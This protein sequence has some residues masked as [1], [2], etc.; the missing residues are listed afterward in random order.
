MGEAA[1]AALALGKGGEGLTGLAK[2]LASDPGFQAAA[3]ALAQARKLVVFYGQEGL[4][5]PGTRR[6]AQACARLLQSTGHAGKPDSGLVAVWGAGNLQGA[7]DVGLRPPEAG[8]ASA[9]TGAQALY[10]VGADPVGDDSAMAESARAASTLVVQELFLSATARLADVVLPAQSFV[11]RQGS[12]T[13]GERR[14]QRFYPALPAWGDTRP[15]WLISAELGQRLGIPLEAGSVAAV[16]AELAASAP[17]YAGL[18]YARLAQVGPQWPRIGDSDL[19]YGG[20]GYSNHQGLGVKLT[21]TA[22]AG[23]LAEVPLD[24]AGRSPAEPA[25]LLVPV[26]RLYDRGIT[27]TQSELLGPRLAPRQLLLHPDDAGDH[28]LEEQL[29]AQIAWDGRS[30]RVAVRLHPGVPRGSA[31]L[32]RSLGLGPTAPTR[33]RISRAEGTP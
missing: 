22:E 6:L 2:E 4:D 16:F 18:V 10:I 28:G 26:A 3:E 29:E 7:W 13:T 27:V 33:V 14:V 12:F 25:L 30:E 31:L 8:N 24:P 1:A 32:P 15:D 20:T 19:Y 5:Y 17:G 11:E 21:S 9:L 23:R